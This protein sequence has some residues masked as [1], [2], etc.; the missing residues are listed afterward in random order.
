MSACIV[1][2]HMDRRGGEKMESGGNVFMMLQLI[3]LV[4]RLLQLLHK[5]TL[6]ALLLCHVR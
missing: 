5:M 3:K 1:Q 2:L 6:I 4:V